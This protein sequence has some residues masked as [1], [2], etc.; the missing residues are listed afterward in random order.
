VKFELLAD[1]DTAPA[2]ATVA[3]DACEEL[4]AVNLRG[5]GFRGTGHRRAGTAGHASETCRA[6]VQINVTGLAGY[7]PR[8]DCGRVL[9][10]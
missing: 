3:F 4:G 6:P 9:P 7:V 8:K 2:G 1:L 5:T 10:A